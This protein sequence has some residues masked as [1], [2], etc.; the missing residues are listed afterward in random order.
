MKDELN[1]QVDLLLSEGKDRFQIWK[2]LK[3]NENQIQTAT[4][5]E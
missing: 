2:R 1:D 5:F 3:D 4:L